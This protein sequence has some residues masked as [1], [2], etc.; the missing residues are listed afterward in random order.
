MCDVFIFAL[1][2]FDKMKNEIFNVGL[3]EA[4]LSKELCEA[5]KKN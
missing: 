1:N 3:S 4:N 2:N 5:I